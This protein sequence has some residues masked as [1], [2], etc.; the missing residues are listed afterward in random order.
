MSNSLTGRVFGASLKPAWTEEQINEFLNK[1]KGD[2]M[3]YLINH[4]KDFN[5]QG[6]LAETHTH[7]YLEYTNPR[8]ITTVA[9]LLEV[10]TNFIEVIRNKK[11]YLRYL[12]HMDEQDKYIYDASE[13]YTNHNQSYE[14]LVRGN[15]ITDKEIAEYIIQGR[16]MELIGLVP[17]GRLRTI[18]G[19]IHFDNS[20]LVLD[21]IRHL[22]RKMDDIVNVVDSVD[23]F[24]KDAGELINNGI[25]SM[26][27]SFEIIASEMIKV[28]KLALRGT[29]K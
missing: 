23:R 11:G 5:E 25:M 19:F 7:I 17:A 20:N 3:V 14:M 21:E 12:T 18:Q 4:D 1:T 29:R 26:T 10:E 15:S 2:I 9:N 27:E 8:K 13:V 22:N 28:R 24:I 16:G 6:E